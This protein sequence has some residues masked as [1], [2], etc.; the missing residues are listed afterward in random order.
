[1]SDYIDEYGF[2][3]LQPRLADLLRYVLSITDNGSKRSV[4]VEPCGT[5]YD[6]LR[7]LGYLKSV[8]QYIS[9]GALI[10]IS[11]KGVRYFEEEAAYRERKAAWEEQL[12]DERRKEHAHDWR[13]NIVNGVYAIVGA[14]IGYLLGRI[15]G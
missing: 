6:E 4:M 1:M 10:T 2:T 14:L 15:A 9:G 11:D 8:T 13:L 12:E 3:P 5:E 7:D